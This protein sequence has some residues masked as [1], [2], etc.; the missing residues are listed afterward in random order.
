MII[1]I[2]LRLIIFINLLLIS[3]VF[4][5]VESLIIYIVTLWYLKPPNYFLNHR[6]NYAIKQE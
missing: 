1:I 3:F 6:Q 5:D 2:F 4:G